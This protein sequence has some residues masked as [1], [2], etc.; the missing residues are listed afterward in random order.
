MQHISSTIVA[1]LSLSLPLSLPLSL[2]LSIYLR[3]IDAAYFFN[4]SSICGGWRRRWVS[5]R[6]ACEESARDKERERD[7]G[8]RDEEGGGNE[9]EREREREN[10][11]PPTLVEQYLFLC[12]MGSRYRD[13]FYAAVT[14]PRRLASRNSIVIEWSPSFSLSFTVSF[15]SSPFS[16]YRLYFPCAR[17]LKTSYRFFS[18]SR[19]TIFLFSLFTFL[20]YLFLIKCVFY[21]S[22]RIFYPLIDSLINV[23]TNGN[24]KKI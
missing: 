20:S 13:P 21:F 15:S 23:T 16:F 24:L 10:F 1:P 11:W 17:T 12:E 8:N 3:S 9:R 7:E 18:T 22:K 5:L 19:M 2:S 14:A 6:S 4:D